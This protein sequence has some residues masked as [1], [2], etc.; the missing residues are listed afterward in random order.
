MA[1]PVQKGEQLAPLAL[2]SKCTSKKRNNE[3]H[4]DQQWKSTMS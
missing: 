3:R 2:K 1:Q 4:W